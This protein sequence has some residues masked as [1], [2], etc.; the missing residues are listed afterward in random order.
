MS[1]EPIPPGGG[2]PVGQQE[3]EGPD[4]PMA[5]INPTIVE[6]TNEER[7]FDGCLSFLGL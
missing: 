7:D 2:R 6:A 5:L 1:D 3:R 4:P